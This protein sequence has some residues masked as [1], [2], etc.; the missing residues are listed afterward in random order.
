MGTQRT[1]EVPLPEHVEPT[2]EDAEVLAAAFRALVH[3]RYESGG[4]WQQ[5]RRRLE[6]EGWSVGCGLTW[7]VE[8]RRG[9]ELEE[10]C[11]ATRDEAFRRLDHA[12]RATTSAGCP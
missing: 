7:H 5:V 9:R 6:S 11:G 4:E 1:I 3:L 10:A 8:A 12:T 2:S